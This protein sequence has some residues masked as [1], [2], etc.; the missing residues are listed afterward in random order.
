MRVGAGEERRSAPPE[1][2]RKK[3]ARWE[4]ICVEVLRKCNDNTEICAVIA[5]AKGEEPEC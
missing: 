3:P 4:N 5:A 1:G 2:R